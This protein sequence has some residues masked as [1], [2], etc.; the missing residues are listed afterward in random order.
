MRKRKREEEENE[1]SCEP[2]CENERP[3]K[4]LKTLL[5]RKSD[6]VPFDKSAGTELALPRLTSEMLTIIENAFVSRPY[7][8]ISR[9]NTLSISTQDFSDLLPGCW[10]NDTIVNY[11]FQI[12]E[13][14]GKTKS[15]PTVLSINAQFFTMLDSEIR[16]CANDFLQNTNIFSFEI[17]L[18]PICQSSHWYLAEIQIRQKKITLYDSLRRNNTKTLELLTDFVVQES[19]SQHYKF[20]IAHW[21]IQQN[22]N[23]PIQTNGTDCGV[24]MCAIAEYLT[25]ESKLNFSQNHMDY[26]RK[27][28]AYEIITNQIIE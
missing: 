19:K 22:Q 11:Y 10:L 5:E 25:R 12:L 17:V 16:E 23:T 24:F 3:R 9:I 26:F 1:R 13:H 6:V 20:E 28:I 18:I 7:T 14:R 15:Y 27:K 2:C 21:Q 4:K 8:T